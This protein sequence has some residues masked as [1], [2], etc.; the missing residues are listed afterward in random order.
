MTTPNSAISEPYKH[1][2]I[3]KPIMVQQTSTMAKALFLGVVGFG[4]F[5]PVRIQAAL[6]S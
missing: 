2:K 5:V 1:L 3:A 4:R 6:P